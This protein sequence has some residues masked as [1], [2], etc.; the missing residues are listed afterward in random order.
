MADLQ[1][2]DQCRIIATGEMSWAIACGASLR[3]WINQALHSR[4]QFSKQ[5]TGGTL[6]IEQTSLLFWLLS[7][8]L[9]NTHFRYAMCSLSPCTISEKRAI[10][11]RVP[12]SPNVKCDASI[13]QPCLY[14]FNLVRLCLCTLWPSF[15]HWGKYWRSNI[16]INTL[17]MDLLEPTVGCSSRCLA[18]LQARLRIDLPRGLLR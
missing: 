1:C 15:G 14:F 8:Q 6:K 4:D 17:R 13:D 18:I 7:L 2:T 12:K 5:P 16:W 11:S 3:L 10:L 9:R